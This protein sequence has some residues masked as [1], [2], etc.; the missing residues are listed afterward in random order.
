MTTIMAPQHNYYQ[1]FGAGDSYTVPDGRF[2][3]IF[4]P[5]GGAFS[6]FTI[7]MPRNPVADQWLTFTSTSV[8]SGVIMHG[9]P[10]QNFGANTALT[11]ISPTA[12][13][14]RFVWRAPSN[15]WYQMP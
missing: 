6:G 12:A 14:Q 10:G 7:T 1:P 2:A 8:I 5:P 11:S 3:I 9:Q 15:T 4:D 13:G